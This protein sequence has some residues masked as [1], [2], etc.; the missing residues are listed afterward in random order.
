MLVHSCHKTLADTIDP[1]AIAKMFASADEQ[2]KEHACWK[3]QVNVDSTYRGRLLL[4]IEG[5]G[6][7]RKKY[8]MSNVF[9]SPT[10]PPPLPPPSPA[11]HIVL[12]P[13][14]S[15]NYFTYYEL[16]RNDYGQLIDKS[17]I[18]KVHVFFLHSYFF[19]VLMDAI[20]IQFIL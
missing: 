11:F 8:R 18:P 2:R 16:E 14:A 13:L 5:G 19:R 9:F 15:Q 17:L 10:P 1:V 4:L 6:G 7:G 20:C 3:V 12:P